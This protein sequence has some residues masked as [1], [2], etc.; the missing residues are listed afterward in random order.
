MTL[1]NVCIARRLASGWGNAILAAMRLAI[2]VALS[3][4]VLYA[5][6]YEARIRRTSYGVAHI[7]AKDTGSLGF[8]DGYA[9]AED[10]L[11]TIADQVIKVRGERSRYFGAGASNENL[12]TD[13]TSK[14]FNLTEDGLHEVEKQ[15]R[16]TREW[17]AGWVAGYNRYLAL[18]GKDKVAGWCRGADWVMPIKVADLAGYQRLLALISTQYAPL[19]A[20]AAPPTTSGDKSVST[21]ASIEMPDIEVGLSNG[22]ALGREK[23]ESGHGMLIANPHY[24]WVGSNRFWEKHL[25]I[26][27]K[28]DV[29]GVSLIGMPDVAIGFNKDLAWT[30]TVSAG[31]RVVLYSLDLVPGKPTTYKYGTGER[32]M[33]SKKITIA[34]KQTD[35]SIKNLDREVWFSHY[36]PILNMPGIGWTAKR[37]ITIRDANW[38]SEGRLGQ[39]NAMARSH[40]LKEFQNAHAKYQGTMWVNTIATTKEGVAFYVDVSATPK[41]SEEAIAEWQKR[42]ESDPLTKRMY[43]GGSVLLDGSDP[44]FEWVKDAEARG[45]GTVP[46]RDVPKIERTDY[47][48]NANDS[49]WLANSHALLAGPY[50][51]LHGEQ[52]TPRS[53]RTRNNDLTIDNQSPDHAAGSDGKFNLDEL[54]QAILSN[55]NLAGELL[56]DELVSRCRNQPAVTIDGSPADLALACDALAKWD[57]RN[58]LDS[59]G[60]VLFKEF[61][62]RYEPQDLPRKGKLWDVDFDPADPVHTPNT[63][64]AGPLALEN[65]ARAMLI[66]QS[67]GLAPDVRLGDVQYADKAG[68]RIPIHGGDGA[69]DGVLNMQHNARNTTT[70]EPMDN[71]AQVKGSRFL[72]EKGYPVVHGSSFL[73]ALEF[74]DQ[75]PHAKAFLTYSQSGDPASEH[76]TDQTELFAKKQWRPILFAEKDIAADVKREYK[77][78][79]S[80]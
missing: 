8:G 13:F 56:R 79:G 21:A 14:S 50:S 2:Y 63:L 9:Q 19:I 35:G 43:Q 58:D 65:L 4:V 49:F 5:A 30:H 17:L 26:P 53:L 55:R 28:L 31:K 71:P 51:P 25:R 44:R 77:V 18:T 6:D 45:A 36:G 67:R 68:R 11:C 3:S 64:A 23:T 52:R 78:K 34:V 69:Y 37:A 24:P 70:L 12:A 32:T 38:D 74:T 59:R 20:T 72:T 16:E 60:S 46:Y 75:G 39:H 29:Y 40:N 61:I 80:R 47:V 27:G 48:F 15:P 22:W 62:G 66:M 7:E 76:F 57:L 33:T 54:T 42:R 73:M 41:L 10:H 1:S